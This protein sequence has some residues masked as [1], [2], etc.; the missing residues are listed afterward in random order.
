MSQ[1]ALLRLEALQKNNARPDW[2]NHD[3]YRLLCKEDLLV[4]A[5]ERIKSK[6]GNMTPGTDGHTLDGSSMDV[7]R[8]I[9]RR[10]RDES[11]QFNPSRREYIPKA[12]G[13]MR[14]LGIPSPRDKIVQEAIRMVLEAIYESPK[15]PTCLPCSHGFRP[16][17]GTHTA[18]REFKGKWSGITWII[19]GD[20]KSCFDEIDH[21]VLISLLRKRI[22]DERF[23]SL[24]WKGLRTG[25]LWKKERHGSFI[26]SPQGSVCSPILANVYLH[27]LDLFVEELRKKYEKGRKR[28]DS[29]EYICISSRRRALLRGSGGV[30][31]PE[32]KDFTRRMR[33]MPSKDFQDPDFVRLKYIRYA[34][35]WIVGVIGPRHL[36]ETVRNEIRS[37]LRDRLK[38]ELSEEKTRITHARTEE[39][40]FL[41][42]RLGIGRS[43]TA[44]VSVKQLPGSRP[45][46][47][48]TTGWLPTLKAPIRKLVRRL[49]DK[50]FCDGDG[51]PQ[52]KRYWVGFEVEHIVNLFSSVNRGLLN[53]YRFARNFGRMTRIQYI[54]Q[55]SLAKTLAH[56]LRI[57]MARVF[58]E[59]GPELVF[60]VDRPSGEKREVRFA[61]NHDWTVQPD[62]FMTGEVTHDPLEVR[63]NSQ[64]RTALRL[65]CRICGSRDRVQM[66]HVR[67]I[68]KMG[69]KVQGFTRVLAKLNRKQ[70]PVCGECHGKIHAGSYDGL[71]LGDL[72]Y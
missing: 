37:F 15:G 5:Y 7:V 50:G 49:H 13:K 30:W 23:L 16:G 25:Y 57:P 19:E 31:T 59:H 9:I 14:P 43:H 64:R 61:L 45:F 38:L 17:R 32:V 36:A 68:R 52:S 1:T 24:I 41:G 21:H 54:L 35:D 28:A 66:H 6:P 67:H 29:P 8:D 3:L 10:L 40:F 62:A 39:A 26:G 72:A 69:E 48:R 20:I 22:A 2:V 60:Q 55:F 12:N 46:K 42:T 51:Y 34:D 27:E 33:S 58:R 71:A 11:F 70:I 44:K 18:L 65:P 47:V 53:Y 56:K 63:I 4:A